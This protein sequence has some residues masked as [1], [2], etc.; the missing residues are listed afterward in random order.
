[1]P[2]HETLPNMSHNQIKREKLEEIL[3]HRF[4]E[5]KA[6]FLK[7]Y[8]IYDAKEMSSILSI[9]DSNYENSL[10]E[11]V[12]QNRILSVEQHTGVGYPAFQLNDKECVYAEL[13]EC[14]PQMY[15]YMT[16]WD[17]VFWLTSPT[18]ITTEIYTLSDEKKEYVLAQDFTLDELAE[19]I[20]KENT[21]TGTA[22]AKPLDLLIKGNSKLFQTFV[23]ALLYEDTREIPLRNNLE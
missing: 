20:L 9:S 4:T 23:T 7:N 8:V 14:L 13:K 5:K 17:I 11:L 16:G 10:Q 12:R 19:F 22:T 6:T 3:E 15:K 18:T 21:P 2:K 1:M